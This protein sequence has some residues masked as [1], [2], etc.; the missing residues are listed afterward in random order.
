MYPCERNRLWGYKW[1]YKITSPSI[2]MLYINNLIYISN[3]DTRHQETIAAL[4]LAP[5]VFVRLSELRAAQWSEIDL[6]AIEWRIL[7]ARMKMRQGSTTSDDAGLGRLPR[8]LAAS[9]CDCTRRTTTDQ[10][11]PC[12]QVAPVG[13]WRPRAMQTR[14]QCSSES[15]HL[16]LSARRAPQRGDVGLQCIWLLSQHHGPT[17]GARSYIL[18]LPFDILEAFTSAH[19]KGG[20]KAAPTEHNANQA[21]YASNSNESKDRR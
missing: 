11:P 16:S 6:E 5:M 10:T 17:H 1:G 14:H 7:G 12:H 18:P 15:L 21:P 9:A 13:P 8:Q 4:K 2:F 19:S 3:A 20:G